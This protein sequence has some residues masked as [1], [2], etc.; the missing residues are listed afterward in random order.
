MGFPCAGYYTACL[1]N[2][3][4]GGVWLSRQ[5]RSEYFS[6]L[7]QV[8]VEADS[9]QRGHAQPLNGNMFAA[10]RL[11]NIEA[12]DRLGEAHLLAHGQK[13]FNLQASYSIIPKL[14]YTTNLTEKKE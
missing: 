6:W 7:G 4:P 11:G 13:V 9:I 3:T 12:L 2:V 8:E 5:R 14:N 10:R 1:R